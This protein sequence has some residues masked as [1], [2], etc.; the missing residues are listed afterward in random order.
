MSLAFLAWLL[1]ILIGQLALMIE[2]HSTRYS[3]S[4]PKHKQ[5]IPT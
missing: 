3:G 1:D 2:Y 5:M 4:M